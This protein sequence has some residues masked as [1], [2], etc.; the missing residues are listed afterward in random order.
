M[1]LVDF[2]YKR[3]DIPFLE[4]RLPTRD[5]RERKRGRICFGNEEKGK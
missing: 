3:Q 5:M 2:W 4:K 1:L